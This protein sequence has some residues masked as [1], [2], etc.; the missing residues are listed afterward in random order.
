MSTGSIAS[1]RT[2]RQSLAKA[3]TEKETS[4]NK[5]LS[6]E[7]AHKMKS[8]F[9]NQKH[10]TKGEDEGLSIKHPKNLKTQNE[11]KIKF[12]TS[13][14]K[15][16]SEI[17]EC[18]EEPA[19]ATSFIKRV[20]DKMARTPA[21]KGKTTEAPMVQ[22]EEKRTKEDEFRELSSKDSLE[23][24]LFDHRAI[25]DTLLFKS[26]LQTHGN[27]ETQ[28]VKNSQN[29]FPASSQR[30]NRRGD[31]RELE[32]QLRFKT[33]LLPKKFTTENQSKEMET[34]E[35]LSRLTLILSQQALGLSQQSKTGPVR[36]PEAANDHCCD[37]GPT[38]EP[39]S[40]CRDAEEEAHQRPEPN[41]VD[42]EQ[43]PMPMKLRARG[44][45]HVGSP[46]Q[47]GD[48]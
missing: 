1:S 10:G 36:C 43:D 11:H 20:V 28:L 30:P 15:N 37:L 13:Y 23:M 39:L 31:R 44:L 45:G 9:G 8:P 12:K 42:S 24:P 26:A 7:Q 3:A 2:L 38:D 5:V 41:P 16:S 21:S 22:I 35:A 40:T 32:K 19:F 14:L 29:S 48:D 18:Q 34:S 46:D 47:I 17:G 27:G 25:Q 4:D 6:S 33:K